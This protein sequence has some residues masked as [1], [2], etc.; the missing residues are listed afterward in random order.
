MTRQEDGNILYDAVPIKPMDT[1]KAVKI[2]VD[3]LKK[4]KMLV[5]VPRY[6]KFYYN[7][8]RLMP[9]M[10]YKGAL[11]TMKKYRGVVSTNQQQM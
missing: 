4:N 1:D 5:F 7:L 8:Q 10:I 2:L 11:R 9:G 6:A 3:G